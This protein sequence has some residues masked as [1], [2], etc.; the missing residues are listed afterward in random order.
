MNL[1]VFLIALGMMGILVSVFADSMG[2]GRPGF[3]LNQ[4][5][6]LVIS[7]LIAAVGMVKVLFVQNR[8]LLQ[9]LTWVYIIGI[10]FA[11]LMPF[12]FN[13]NHNSVL[14]GLNIFSLRDFAVNLVGFVPL[15][16]L[17]MMSFGNPKGEARGD[18]FMRAIVVSGVGCLISLF[19]EVS[20]YYFI[21]GRHSS[22]WDLMANTVGAL[23]GVALFVF[24]EHEKGEERA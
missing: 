12:S 7:V 2:L 15:G 21:T 11:G 4:M 19:L 22:F 20:Q 3:G 14:L 5:S 13:H 9:V 16:Y 23:V 18:L 8:T 1:E 17:L 10:L 6:G 24:M